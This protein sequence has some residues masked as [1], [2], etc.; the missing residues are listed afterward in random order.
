[1]CLLLLPAQ[2]IRYLLLW[3]IVDYVEQSAALFGLHHIE[4]SW[5]FPSKGEEV[6]G[7]APTL[8]PTKVLQYGPSVAG[9]GIPVLSVTTTPTYHPTSYHIWTYSAKTFT[10][11][12]PTLADLTPFAGLLTIL[13]RT[14]I[15]SFGVLEYAQ[16]W[17]LSFQTVIWF[18]SFPLICWFANTVQLSNF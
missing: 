16:I 9:R 8:I 14:L 3:L 10:C 17:C 12:Y 15:V 7:Y 11:D 1:M 5:Y 2:E 13:F 18:M 4:A 6:Y